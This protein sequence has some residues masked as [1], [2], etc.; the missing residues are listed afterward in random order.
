M[1]YLP[2]IVSIFTL[3]FVFFLIKKIQRAPRGEGLMIKISQAIQ[4]GANAFLRR[5]FK[6]MTLILGL[7]AVLILVIT[8][9]FWEAFIFLIGAAV[10]ALAGY[11]GMMIAV[12]ANVRTAN[13]AQANF[14]KSFQ[15]AFLG[16][17][18]MG[19]L[20]VGLGLLGVGLIWLLFQDTSL[21]ISYAF[22]SSL[23]AFFL[24][25]GGGIFTKSADVGADL[26]GKI[27]KGIPEDDPRNP[28]VIADQVGDNVGDIAGMGSDLFES[29][30]S[31][32][33]AAMVLGLVAFGEKGLLLP[34]ML[35][36][37]GLLS[38]ILGSFFVKI[39]PEVAKKTFVEQTT[40]IR[41]AMEKGILLA[42]GLMVVA[43]YFIISNFF[44]DLGLFWALLAGLAVGFLIGKATE[45]YTS[46]GKKPVLS[47][48]KV[49]QAGS[50]TLIIT[51][52]SVGMQS[53]LL[54]VL[55]VALVT[56]IAYFF[57]GLYGIAIASV[58]ILAVLG[59]YLS[60]D[61]YGPIADNAAGISQ[62]AGLGKEVRQRTEALD[63]VGN[64]T[65]AT[66]K[67]FAI[68]S[69]ALSAL[70]WLALFFEMAY[71]EEIRFLDPNIIAGLFV[72]VMLSFLFCSLTL[73]SVGRGAFEMVREVRRQFKEMPGIMEGKTKPDY[74]RCVDLVTKKALKE[75]IVPGVLV[76]LTPILVWLVLGVEGV[77]GVLAGSLIGGFLLALMLANSGGAWDNAKKWIE[78]GNLG[79]KGSEAHKV[80]VVGDT[81]GDPLKDT[82]GPSLNILIKL[83][84]KVAVIF[85]PL[86]LL[87]G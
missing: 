47:I 32:I 23:V 72:G 41:K 57:G 9:D 37:A 44:E 82:A 70:A 76:V 28:A 74:G 52:L 10:S 19:F 30:I 11:L 45:Y 73:N 7:L 66:G 36:S 51:G 3:I 2:I 81:V 29:Y 58:G 15:I 77:G 64:S 38:S 24:R 8:Q 84:G 43:A 61:C 4:E 13:A 42:N 67:G 6:T 5:E 85:V 55:G 39:S 71:L 87:F 18:V 1:F 83:I 86:F 56:V 16:G 59:I 75:M 12:R 49:S 54:P 50:P 40:A 48:A 60:T 65:A 17:G 63:T 33:I 35:A 79:G 26:V 46:E 27:E 78:A 62:M 20:V 34:L 31:A 69:A 25:V 21:L 68:G 53:T 80:A 22:G 14:A